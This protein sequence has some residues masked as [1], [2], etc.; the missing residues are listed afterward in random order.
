MAH[1][2]QVALDSA[3]PHALADWWAE[4]LGWKVEPID[5]AV[6]T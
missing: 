6:T 2:F 1:G 5:E 4:A 3:G